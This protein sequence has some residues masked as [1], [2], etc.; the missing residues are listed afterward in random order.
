[1]NLPDLVIYYLAEVDSSS[2][3]CF[4][5]HIPPCIKSS[6]CRQKGVCLQ[7]KKHYDVAIQAIPH[8][9]QEQPVTV[10]N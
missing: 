7:E 5:I 1:M 6:S 8:M 9:H 4:I 10:R 3:V 2:V